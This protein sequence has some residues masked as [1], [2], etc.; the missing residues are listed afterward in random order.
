[1]ATLLVD[2]IMVQFVLGGEVKLLEEKSFELESWDFNP[3]YAWG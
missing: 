1:M 3:L 2:M